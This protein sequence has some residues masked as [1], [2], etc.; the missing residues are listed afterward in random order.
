ME[1]CPMIREWVCS[2]GLRHDLDVAPDVF[3][4]GYESRRA[5]LADCRSHF[6]WV[7]HDGVRTDEL[8]ARRRRA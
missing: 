5:H 2:C 6:W 1:G 8:A 4:K 3:R 7:E